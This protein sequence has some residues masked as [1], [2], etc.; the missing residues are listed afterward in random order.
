MSTQT[1]KQKCP[2]GGK[3]ADREG[4]CNPAPGEEHVHCAPS[5]D[6]DSK[7]ESIVVHPANIIAPKP[8]KKSIWSLFK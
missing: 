5:F 3:Y 7:E 4:Y 1:I 2:W 8:K 6:T